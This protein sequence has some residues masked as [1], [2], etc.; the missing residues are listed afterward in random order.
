MCLNHGVW[1]LHQQE[2]GLHAQDMLTILGSIVNIIGGPTYDHL[3]SLKILT[4]I[5]NKTFV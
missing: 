1:T 3:V 4:L 2:N 5:I